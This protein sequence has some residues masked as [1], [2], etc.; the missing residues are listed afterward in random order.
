MPIQKPVLYF[1]D[2]KT[3]LRKKTKVKL[4][5]CLTFVHIVAGPFR[6]LVIPVRNKEG[7]LS[8]KY[9]FAY[10]ILQ[11]LK[12]VMRSKWDAIKRKIDNL[13]TNPLQASCAHW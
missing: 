4:I 13:G 7:C 2:G 11:N 12:A 10:T 8:G 3:I 5:S 9:I 6:L 1:D